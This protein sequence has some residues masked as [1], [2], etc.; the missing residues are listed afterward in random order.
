M[1]D[2][3]DERRLRELSEASE[4]LHSDALRANRAALTDYVEQ[5]RPATRPLVGALGARGAAVA[6]GLTSAP[7]AAGRH[8]LSPRTR[9]RLTPRGA[10]PG[11]SSRTAPRRHRRP[12]RSPASAAQRFWL[13]R[14]QDVASAVN[15]AEL[16]AHTRLDSVHLQASTTTS[17]YG[18]SWD[19]I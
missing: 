4:D 11:R 5:T 16:T 12:Q 1:S 2:T 8:P 19:S 9:P 7:R 6:A 18:A 3:V 14:P 10:A 13:L 17:Y 15:R